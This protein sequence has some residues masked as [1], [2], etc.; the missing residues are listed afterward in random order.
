MSEKTGITP[1]TSDTEKIGC[2]AQ[3]LFNASACGSD[4][5]C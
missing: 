2:V 1:D 4:G 5:A 3:G